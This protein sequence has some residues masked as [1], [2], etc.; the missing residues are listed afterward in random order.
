MFQKCN[1]QFV[2]NRTLGCV[3]WH[4]IYRTGCALL[5]ICNATILS[6]ADDSPTDRAIKQAVSFLQKEVPAWEPENHCFSCHNNGDGARALYTAMRKG[7]TVADEALTATT[8]W[9]D[10][11][12]RWKEN[13]PDGEFSDKKLAA[14]Q[15]A[16]ALSAAVDHGADNDREP[17]QPAA[18]LVAALQTK[19]GSWD[20]DSGG[21]VGTPVTY[22]K[23]LATAV[24]RKILMQ[25]DQRRYQEALNKSQEWLRA[26][27]PK[28]VLDS[29]AA[30]FDTTWLDAQDDRE[31]LADILQLL[32]EGQSPD[33]GWGPF[34]N[35]Q[36]EV[37]DTAIVLLAL[38]RL[39]RS[40]P[41]DNGKT[42]WTNRIERGRNFLIAEQLE[43]GSW[44]ETTRPSGS[45]SYAQRMSTTGWATLAL[46]ST[47]EIGIRDPQQ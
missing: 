13:G 44:I 3:A 14:I 39:S 28:S 16:F 41:I 7:F 19:E 40:V 38:V 24:S 12:N 15:F 5:C 45:V 20:V 35:S 29:A 47:I 6:A 30:V 8:L 46:L 4:A 31:M 36:P 37:F 11:P 32:A 2:S 27:H 21:L 18:E 17:L 43:D 33:G 9:L 34:K 22:G 10:V 42:I 23:Y 25:A 26:N 1:R